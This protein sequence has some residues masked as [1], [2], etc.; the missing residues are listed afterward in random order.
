[1]LFDECA[2]TFSNQ[3]PAETRV[4]NPLI[5]LEGSNIT[6]LEYWFR[7]C[8]SWDSIQMFSFHSD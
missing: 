3:I 1:M 8:K 4:L 7:V 5:Y 6:F 2:V